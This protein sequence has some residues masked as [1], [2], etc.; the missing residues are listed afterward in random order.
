[1]QQMVYCI[2]F[3]RSYTSI[4]Q[5]SADGEHVLSMTDGQLTLT[6]GGGDDCGGGRKSKT[7]VLLH[8]DEHSLVTEVLF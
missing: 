6:Y 7:V 4:G 1:M 3:C 8:C 2:S 5:L